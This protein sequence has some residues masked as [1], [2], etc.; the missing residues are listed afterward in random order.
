[1]DQNQITPPFGFGPLIAL[2]ATHKLRRS[3]RVP[4]FFARSNSIPVTISEFEVAG[5]DVPIVFAPVGTPGE[6][7]TGYVPVAV[8]G[9]DVNENL[10]VVDGQ[11]LSETYMPAYVRRMPFC[12]A[13]VVGGTQPGRIMCVEAASL[14]AT[15]DPEGVAV[16]D[17][18][19]EK[20]EQFKQAEKFVLEVEGELER[21]H[22]LAKL[23]HDLKVIDGFNM[24]AQLPD[25]TPLQFGGMAR[26]NEEKLRNLNADQLRMLIE[27]GAMRLIYA[28]IS[29]IERFQLLVN[30]RLMR[31]SA[32]QSSAAAAGTTA[33]SGDAPVAANDQPA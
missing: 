8:V 26:V 32:A 33:G 28:H 14:A 23:L 16:A 11:W 6:T 19:G 10:L 30:R 17:A 24:T 22:Q 1:M 31:M 2:E 13:N 5:R 27:R 21:T 3:E 9:L 20:S 25:G 15:D 12:T 29:S 18:N 4:E 7:P